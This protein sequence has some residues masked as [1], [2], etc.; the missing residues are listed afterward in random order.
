MGAFKLE[1]Y[2]T[3]DCVVCTHLGTLLSLS[4]CS[5]SMSSL[6]KSTMMML[7]LSSFV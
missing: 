7:K 2:Y 4:A 1:S 3:A 5:T 6:S